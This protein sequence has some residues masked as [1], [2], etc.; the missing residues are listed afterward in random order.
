MR[1]PLK[2]SNV[3]MT[4]FLSKYSRATSPLGAAAILCLSA[5]VLHGPLQAQVDP[6]RTGRPPQTQSQ[7]Q[8]PDQMEPDDSNSDDPS[9][10]DGDSR[11]FDGVD[12]LLR[13][14]SRLSPRLSPSI[15]DSRTWP[16]KSEDR[17]EERPERVIEPP[18]EFQ[19]FVQSSTGKLLPIYGAN[20]FDHVPTTF[21]PLDH[22]PVTP[23]Y[24]IGPNDEVDL[25][26]WGQINFSQRL[27]VDR[28][29]D[30]FI[31]QVGRVSL[32]GLR[33]AQVRETLKNAVGRVYKNFDLSVNMGQLRSIQVF[34]VGQAKRPGNYTVSSLSTL[35]NA[36]FASGG[37]SSSGSM[38]GIQLK[39]GGRLVTTMDLY[40]LLLDGDKSQDAPLEPGDVIYIPRAGARVAVSGSIQN[41]GIYE[42]KQTASLREVLN[43]SGGLSPV[44]A[45]Q[46][47]VLERVDK[48]SVLRSYNVPLTGDGLDHSL[49]DGDIVQLLSVV[50]RFD[51]VVT[52]RGNVADPVRLPWYP[53]MKITDLIPDREALLTRD[54]WSAENRLKPESADEDDQQPPQQQQPRNATNRQQ[55]LTQHLTDASY[56][57]PQFRDIYSSDTSDNQSLAASFG[58]DRRVLSRHFTA[59]ND[60][61]PAAPDID[62][63]YAAIERRDPKTL[64]SRLIPFDLAKVVIDHNPEAD[65]ALEPGDI[66]DI[67]STADVTTPRSQQTRYVRL[68]GEVRM[69]GVY[70]VNPGETLRDIVRRAGGLTHN[71]YL[72]GAE[73]TRESTKQEQQKRYSAYIDQL[74]RDI[75]QSGAT[76][77]GRA[78]SA[79]QESSLQATL[80]SQKTLLQRLRQATPSGRIVLDLEPESQGADALPAIP[81]ENGDRLVVPSNVAT[82][83]IVG[84]VYN[85]ST[86]LYAADLRLGDYLR[87]AGGPTRYADRSHI[88]VIR[89]DGSVVAKDGRSGLFSANFAALRMYPGDSI[90][91]PT[92]VTKTTALRNILDWSQVIS[93]FGLGAA[94]INVLK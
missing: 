11:S 49:Q 90:V 51:G 89:A 44:A 30:I 79:N 74:E 13:M 29:G 41:P 72:Y 83:N 81:L 37:P 86:R 3:L 56:N 55:P 15:P 27:A 40:E 1:T 21:A 58:D 60:L 88:F 32:A 59:K 76:L 62:W 67:F 36:L 10:I 25:R 53:G 64:T 80:A 54:Y 23:D 52:L 48:H 31:P 17:R 22:V 57:R 47:A 73:F 61:Q 46:H 8:D 63:S 45:G 16:T 39:R 35:V 75:N 33:F 19:L 94:A 93:N 7:S 9:S 43:Y 18:N 77:F 20:L 34:V 70:S 71:A 4:G 5:L 2:E 12:P 28:T 85:Q 6:F 84:T 78:L 82:V 38:R 69:A 66:I 92:N 91:V 68:E 26:V 14:R 42:L 24:T 87:E 50:P 65:L